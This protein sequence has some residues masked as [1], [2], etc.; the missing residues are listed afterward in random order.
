M[1]IRLI[2]IAFIFLFFACKKE[3]GSKKD[4]QLNSLSFSVLTYNIAGLPQGISSSNPL[5]NTPYIGKLIN[6]YDIVHVQEDFN[7][8]D[9]LIKQNEHSF[10]TK[11]KAESVP[12][13]DGLNTL[14]NYE[15]LD[16]KRIKWNDCTAADCL[17]PKGFSFTK[18]NFNGHFIVDFYNVHANAGSEGNE[19]AARRKNLTQ[20]MEFV[21]A[22]SGDNP[23]IIM[24]DFNCRYSRTGDIIR[25]VLDRNFK[26]AWIEHE[27]N[28]VLPPLDDIGFVCEDGDGNGPNCEVV[29]KIFYRGTAE[30]ELLLTDFELPTEKFTLE[31][32]WLS[33]HRPMFAQF[34]I[35][36]KQ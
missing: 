3:D 12:F 20:L 22:N 5:K 8:H 14:S 33:D 29:D 18:I 13:S 21:D 2:S 24:G 26:D 15:I 28:G 7:Y 32:K 35:N 23:V 30:H 4:G 34:V 11:P 1:K 27:R 6:D 16:L 19:M 31:G 36:R 10:I 9:L 25:T 17:T